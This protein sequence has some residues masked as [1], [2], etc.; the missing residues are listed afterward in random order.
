MSSLKRPGAP[1]GARPGNDRSGLH[2]PVLR[3][4]RQQS[5]WEWMGLHVG[6]LGLDLGLGLCQDTHHEEVEARKSE[7]ENEQEST[8]CWSTVSWRSKSFRVWKQSSPA[9]PTC[10]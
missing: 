3:E 1:L 7:K 4:H 10:R 2:R 8:R 9:T 6:Y 5:W